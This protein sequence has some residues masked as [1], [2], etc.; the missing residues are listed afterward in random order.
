[1]LGLQNLQREAK[2]KAAPSNAK[3]KMPN[4]MT[5]SAGWLH[6]PTNQWTFYSCSSL[7]INWHHPL[8]Y[9]VPNV[10]KGPAKT[11]SYYHHIS[12]CTAIRSSFSCACCSLAR[13]RMTNAEGDEYDIRTHP[14]SL[15]PPP[16]LKHET[17]DE[18]TLSYSLNSRSARLF[19]SSLRSSWNDRL[20]SALA[21]ERQDSRK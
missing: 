11:L 6:S 17:R 9:D 13:N 12:V 1:M 10:R 7:S 21:R 20:H 2:A 8:T 14:P 18:L 16:F 4:I 19:I 3:R 5:A 15:H